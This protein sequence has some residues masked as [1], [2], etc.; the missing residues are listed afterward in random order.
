MVIKLIQ[1]MTKVLVPI[2]IFKQLLELEVG[3]ARKEALGFRK[4]KLMDVITIELM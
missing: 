3:V 2:A 4:M 1:R